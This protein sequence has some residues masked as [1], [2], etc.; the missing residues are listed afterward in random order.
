MNGV[1]LV[2]GILFRHLHFGQV[3]ASNSPLINHQNIIL[4]Q[5]I[6]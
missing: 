4:L 2:T 5:F 3:R 1:R 6:S